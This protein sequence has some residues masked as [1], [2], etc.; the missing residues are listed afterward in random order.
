MNLTHF[1]Q[2]FTMGSYGV[3]ID[4]LGVARKLVKYVI[5]LSKRRNFKK[6][7]FFSQAA[8]TANDHFLVSRNLRRFPY[9]RCKLRNDVV[10]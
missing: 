9:R 5:H 1:E 7:K 10:N 6:N 2:K 4:V 8:Q 3:R